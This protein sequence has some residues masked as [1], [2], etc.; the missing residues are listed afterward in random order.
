MEEA[1]ALALIGAKQMACAY[2]STST[3]TPT[4]P[5]R[6]DANPAGRAQPGAQCHRGDERGRVPASRANVFDQGQSARRWSKRAW[7]TPGRDIPEIATQ[8]FQPFVT[9]KRQGMGLGLSISRTIIEAHGGELWVEPNPGGGSIF[10]FTLR[11]AVKE[12]PEMSE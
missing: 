11:A 6:Q 7:P 8:L 10:C 12:Q 5:R 4:G 2:A 3:R 1:S 9:T